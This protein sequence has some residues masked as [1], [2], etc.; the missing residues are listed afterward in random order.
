MAWRDRPFGARA[1]LMTDS[2]VTLG[3]LAKGRSSISVLNSICRR[4]AAIA[5]SQRL[6]LHWRY[7]RTFRN[8]ADA[9]SRGR[10]FGALPQTDAVPE[11][12]PAGAELPE[13]FYKK[14]RG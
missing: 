7:V 5:L 2:Q 13:F 14:T 8:H 12:L 3:A 9:P 1:V 6:R 10:P 4:V 11:R